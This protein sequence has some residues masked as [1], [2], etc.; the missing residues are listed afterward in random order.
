MVNYYLAVD[1]GASSGRH[2][3]AHLEDGK[4]VLE[5]IHRFSNGMIE[6]DG[7]KRWNVDELF[8]QII[9]GLKKCKELEKIPIS[10]GIDTWAV[11]Y[12]LLDENDN[13][14]RPCFGYR[15]SRTAGMDEEVYKIIPEENLYERTGI[16]K[17]IFNTIYQLMADKCDGYLDNAKSFLMV[18]DYLH[19]LLTG[20]KSNEY[21]N[22]STT[23]L[24]NPD[25]MSWDYELIGMLGFNEDLFGEI[26]QPGTC[27]GTFS[28]SVKAEVGFDCKVVLP[29][30]HD[31]AS[32]VFAVP[33]TS[34]NVL[35][36]SSG[37]WSLL[38]S[39][40]MQAI[41]T[42]EAMEANFTN[43][44]GY[45]GRFRF[46]KNIMGLWMIQSVRN[47]LIAAGQEYSFGELCE[48]A[49]NADID[50]IVDANDEVFLAPESMIDAVKEY[51]RS[52]GQNEPQTPGELAKVIYHSLAICYRKACEEVES[53]TG[54]H[55]D[56]INVVGGGSKAGYLN[57]LTTETIGKTV[58]AGPSEATAL[59][60]IGA[61][62]VAAGEVA[63][64]KEFR[65][66]LMSDI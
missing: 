21:T 31:T 3:L 65:N 43:E 39:E 53:I 27:I 9:I 59:G 22:C 54:K 13:V 15:D 34:E 36:I 30:T 40:N 16:Q 14:V 52:H 38:G 2:M 41:C 10:M 37:T 6:M 19:Y 33:N 18:P 12:V 61:Q 42:K 23:Q 66:I 60:N 5:E 26:K 64:L 51:C 45:D 55:F 17:A 58:I 4:V 44:G 1:I 47:E 49:E 46:L 50:S 57:K 28:D 7:H 24:L 11:D 56:I 8:K 29:P 62:M 35:Y 25:T 63:G 20:V 32:A 48:M